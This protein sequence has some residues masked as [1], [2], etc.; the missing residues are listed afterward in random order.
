LGEG[1]QQFYAEMDGQVLPVFQRLERALEQASATTRQIRQVMQE[2]EATAA[3]FFRLDGAGAN[4]SANGT[5]ANGLAAN[6]A[7]NGSANGGANGASKPSGLTY[8]KLEGGKATGTLKGGTPFV[9]GAGDTDAISPNDVTQGQLGDCYLMASLA[10]VARAN[11]QLIRDMIKDNGDGTYDV[12]FKVPGPFGEPFSFTETVTA[13]FPANG[14]S[15]LYAG[16]GDTG[17]GAQPEIWVALIEKAY[18]EST[19]SGKYGDISGGVAARALEHITGNRSKQRDVEDVDIDDI[20]DAFY[21]G[22]AITI[23]TPSDGTAWSTVAKL[24]KP[25]YKNQEL[26]PEHSY[27]VTA[28][29]RAAKTVT[30]R[31]PWGWNRQET[32]IPISEFN[33]LFHRVAF[34]PTR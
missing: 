15:P 1:A 33:S 17:P 34:N 9:Q 5:A 19:S 18:A 27:Y 30:I 14:A 8:G 6:G 16:F 25:R 2:T 32:T 10:A 21:R 28:V 4:G 13:E 26:V 3:A 20:A 23:D 24:T 22:D 31:N 29:D 12:T 7:A 11:P